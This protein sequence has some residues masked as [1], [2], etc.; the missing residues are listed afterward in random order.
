MKKQFVQK[1]LY[2]LLL[3][4]QVGLVIAVFVVNYLSGTKAGVYRHVYTRRIHYMEG[5]YNST[6]IQWQ[7]LFVAGL[8]ILL[9][10]L[11]FSS[12]K[13]RMDLFYKIQIALAIL[14][15]FFIIFVMNSEFFITMMVYPYI[16]IVFEI[17]F[18]IQLMVVIVLSL[19]KSKQ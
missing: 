14:L 17:V 9:F 12:I 15:S 6:S 11:L 18:A 2:F 8:C 19:I 5:L 10:I 7:S 1:L 4:I 3:F 13:K 16:I